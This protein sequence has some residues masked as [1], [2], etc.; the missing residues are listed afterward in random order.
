MLIKK[1]ILSALAFTTTLSAKA[2]ADPYSEAIMASPEILPEGDDNRKNLIASVVKIFSKRTSE[3]LEKLTRAATKYKR[4]IFRKALEVQSSLQHFRTTPEILD[5]ICGDIIITRTIRS[6][7]EESTAKVFVGLNKD[8]AELIS[9]QESIAG[10]ACE[11]LQA[12]TFAPNMKGSIEIAHVAAKAILT[13]M[14]TDD[15]KVIGDFITQLG[16]AQASLSND[17]AFYSS[18]SELVRIYQLLPRAMD[19]IIDDSRFSGIPGVIER[20][21]DDLQGALER[22]E[23]IRDQSLNSLP[24]GFIYNFD[25]KIAYKTFFPNGNTDNIVYDPEFDE[26]FAFAKISQGTFMMGSPEKED[27]HFPIDSRTFTLEDL[28]QVTINYGFEMQITPV[29]ERQWRK[30]MQHPTPQCLIPKSPSDDEPAIC[31]TWHEAMEF[32]RQL[33]KI[34]K[35]TGYY[36]RLPTD[37]EWEYA[38]RAGTSTPFFWG[39]DPSQYKNY[40]SSA[41]QKVASKMPNPWGLFDVIGSD[42]WMLDAFQQNLGHAPVINPNSTILN[43]CTE[44]VVVRNSSLTIVDRRYARSANRSGFPRDFRGGPVFRLVRYKIKH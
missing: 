24:E 42:T 28:H 12:Q 39:M 17:E 4:E 6:I 26:L 20:F 23:I 18:A 29:T 10:K 32:C 22:R 14:S 2:I 33:N 13:V 8:H 37:A 36:Y 30:V 34:R 43:R 31:I 15:A 35:E 38:I 1:L 25:E 44:N 21:V 9:I 40:M 19:K 5:T 41:F 27:G 3:H 7:V 11:Q 16:I